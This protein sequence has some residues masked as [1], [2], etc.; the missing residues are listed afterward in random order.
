MTASRFVIRSR[1]RYDHRAVTQACRT[2]LNPQRERRRIK[3][4]FCVHC[5][6]SPLLANLFLHYAFDHWMQ[7]H[8]PAIP[9]ER[10]ADDI[11]CHCRNEAQA[12]QLK[13]V[14]RT[15]FEQC[16]LELHP[17]KTKIVYC[18]DA[19]RRGEYPQ[20]KF[21]FLGYEFRPRESRNSAGRLFVNFTPAIS[22]KASKALRREI[23]RWGLHRLTSSSLEEIVE[24]IYPIVDGWIRCYGRF[25]RAVLAGAMRTIDVYLMR[26]ALRKFKR[27]KRH[28]RRGW[29][30]LNG[31]RSRQST[32]LPT[33]SLR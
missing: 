1:T 7:K 19:N 5:V 14:L 13:R 8:H 4:T 23:R 30:W 6:I 3:V 27:L 11:L 16:M 10:Y 22:P 26:W 29:E 15:R 17:D 9:F 25:N 31:V 24:W 20:C 33:W 32:L 18:Q 2:P 12:Q 21:D 28:R